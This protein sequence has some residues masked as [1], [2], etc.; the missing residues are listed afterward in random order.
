MKIS[1]KSWFTQCDLYHRILLFYFAEVK[2]IIYV[3]V[4]LKRVVYNQSHRVNCPQ[5]DQ[6][7]A[8]AP[9]NKD[10]A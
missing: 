6:I 7:N 2:R 10:F 4:N 3:S 5:Y 8:D 1:D 9:E